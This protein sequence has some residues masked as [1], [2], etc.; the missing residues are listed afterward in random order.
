MPC[1]CLHGPV[2]SFYVKATVT[3]TYFCKNVVPQRNALSIHHFCN[4]LVIVTY[5]RGWLVAVPKTGK[6][7]ALCL[8][9]FMSLLACLFVYLPVA[10][11]HCNGP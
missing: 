1:S 10:C 5:A 4:E 11:L 7:S 8:L 9:V 2:K 3:P 6:I